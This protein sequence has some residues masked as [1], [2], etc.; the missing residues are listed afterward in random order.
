M[1]N[2]Q[3]NEQ[4]VLSIFDQIPDRFFDDLSFHKYRPVR[5]VNQ[6]S[7]NDQVQ[8]T[9]VSPDEKER[10]RVEL[11]TE[12]IRSIRL[13]VEPLIVDVGGCKMV[14]FT[15]T[16]HLIGTPESLRIIADYLDELNSGWYEQVCVAL[17]SL[18]PLEW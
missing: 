10:F 13:Q 15:R 18:A 1:S 9:S 2:Q 4:V 12:Y 14:D 8:Q 3:P 5:W 11:Q 17:D 16:A 6:A 7:S